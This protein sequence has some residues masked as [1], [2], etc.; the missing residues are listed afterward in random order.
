ML[1][2]LD[3]NLFF[4]ALISPHGL[5][6]RIVKAWQNGRFDLLTC[7]HQIDEIRE[8]SRNP[9]FR[10]LFQAHQA[11]HHAQQPLCRDRVAGATIA[12]AQSRRPGRQLPARSNRRRTAR[13]RRHRG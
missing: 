10:T 12:P 5:P 4:S 11:R 7:Q 1:V 8:A 6:A 9:K 3:S 13:L 2:L